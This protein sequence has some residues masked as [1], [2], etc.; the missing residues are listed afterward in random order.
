MDWLFIWKEA[1]IVATGAFGVLGLLTEYKDKET[2]KITRWG[3]ISLIGVVLSTM[4]GVAAQF[5]ETSDQQ[6]SQAA[7]ASQ[8]LK[9]V[10]GT[11]TTVVG[12]ERLLTSM[13]DATF[14]LDLSV[15][16]A[17][18]TFKKFCERMVEGNENRD[19]VFQKPNDFMSLWSWWPTKSNGGLEEARWLISVCVDVNDVQRLLN[20]DNSA[21]DLQYMIF[22]QSGGD[23]DA[24]EKYTAVHFYHRPDSPDVILS[25]SARSPYVLINKAKVTGLVDLKGATIVLSQDNSLP[26]DAKFLPKS[27]FSIE[28]KNG[29]KVKVDGASFVEVQMKDSVAAYK[30]VVPK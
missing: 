28:T 10:Q 5:K 8:T 13:T 9:I 3:R 6:A 7:A 25:I 15:P 1:S 2:G 11:N 26:A 18:A 22:S 20:G 4:G 21:A 16:C 23:V 14:Y 17:S 19:S 12:I 24:K 27:G 29:Q 30:A